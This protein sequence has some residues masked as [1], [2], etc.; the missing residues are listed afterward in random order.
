MKNGAPDSM[1][2]QQQ[3]CD[4]T[5]PPDLQLCEAVPKD[6]SAIFVLKQ[7]AFGANYLAYTIYQ[8]PKSVSFIQRVIAERR[9]GQRF[10]VLRREGAVIGYYQAAMLHRN[11]LLNYI[12]VAASERG[13]GFGDLLLEDF[14]AY[15]KTL[16]CRALLLDVFAS[17]PDAVNWYSRRGFRFQS[18]QHLSRVSIAQVDSGV[19]CP[20]AI[21][22]G[23]MAE[24]LAEESARGFS[25]V[26]C[27]CSTEGHLELGLIDGHVCKFMDLSGVTAE[28]AM[29]SISHRFRTARD[30]LVLYSTDPLPA[31]WPILTSEKSLRLAKEVC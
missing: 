7:Q 17:N 29:A 21:D 14:E 30:V 15:A 24:A 4:P 16:G 8:A 9:P 23:A 22:K 10:T 18:A 1:A 27:S 13:S 28:L 5:S 3:F 6:A 19:R 26:H 20:L 12:A 11:L 31:A 25:K 2:N